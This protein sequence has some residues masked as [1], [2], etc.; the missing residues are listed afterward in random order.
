MPR[1][2]LSV[3]L[4]VACACGSTSPSYVTGSYDAM[5]GSKDWLF[6]SAEVAVLSIGGRVRGIDRDWGTL[7]AHLQTVELGATTVLDISIRTGFAP[8]E[9]EFPEEGA[10]VVV[11]VSLLGVSTLS[12]DQLDQLEVVR[13][14][15]FDAFH[16]AFSELARQGR[17]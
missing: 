6:D 8:Q 10:E 12:A 16:E 2:L 13:D 7:I 5:F 14:R 9:R 17:R 1:I 4:L 11:K 3:V 15:F